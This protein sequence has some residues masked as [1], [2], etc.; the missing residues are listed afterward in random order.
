[1]G[2][3]NFCHEKHFSSVPPPTINNDRSLITRKMLPICTCRMYYNQK[4][5]FSPVFLHELPRTIVS[6]ISSYKKRLFRRSEKCNLNI[7]H[8]AQSQRQRSAKCSNSTFLAWAVLYE[9]I[10]LMLIISCFWTYNYNTISDKASHSNRSC[11]ASF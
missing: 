4:V 11:Y 1:L 6:Y 9:Y 5:S 7:K 2:Q 10:P 8:L 3:Q